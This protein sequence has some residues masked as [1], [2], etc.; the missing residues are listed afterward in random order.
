MSVSPLSAY[1]SDDT[2]TVIAVGVLAATL[3]AIS[4]ETLGHGVG[5]LGTG[6]HITLLTSIWFRCKGASAIAD[7]G[8]PIGN[9]L[10]GAAAL[11]LFA[12]RTVSPGVRLFLLMFGA[13]NLFWLTGQLIFESLIGAHS[14]DWYYVSL[15]MGWPP[16]WRPVGAA[17]GVCGYM[18]VA[19]WASALIR[20]QRGPQAHAIRLAYAASAASAVIAGLMWRP[21]PFR[22]AVEGFAAVGIAPLGLLGVAQRASRDSGHVGA[23]SVPRSWIWISICAVLFGIF[24]FVQASGLGSMAEST[25]SAPGGN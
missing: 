5:C 25:L 14:D 24:L 2:A 3:A 9:L 20:K 13:L 8:G 18:L 1:S 11:A 4:H 7:A 16:L 21:E 22:S 19:R 23:W 15:Q 10:A 6:G 12:C 17:V